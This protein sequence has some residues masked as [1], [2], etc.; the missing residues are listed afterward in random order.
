MKAELFARKFQITVILQW[1]CKVTTSNNN[2]TYLQPDNNGMSGTDGMLRSWQKLLYY[3]WINNVQWKI[4]I[5]YD[6]TE[7]GVAMSDVLSE[8]LLKPDNKAAKTDVNT[9]YM[10]NMMFFLFP[11]DL[12]GF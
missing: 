10:W 4:F 3:D 12:L 5:V 7:V 11:L 9:V 1:I 2:K 6:V 8:A